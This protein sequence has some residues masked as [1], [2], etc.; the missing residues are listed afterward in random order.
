M[1]FCPKLNSSSFTVT[2][3]R[4]TTLKAKIP[5]NISVWKSNFKI[6]DGD[7]DNTAKSL[8]YCKEPKDLFFLG[9]ILTWKMTNT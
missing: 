3:I 2:R 5:K 9:K 8:I 4:N 6:W 1:S 7:G